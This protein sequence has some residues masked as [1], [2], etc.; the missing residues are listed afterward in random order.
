MPGANDRSGPRRD[1]ALG[2]GG[3]G[4][5][6]SQ[7]GF[8]AVSMLPGAERADRSVD[9]VAAGAGSALD[10]F[11]RTSRS[12]RSAR[13]IANGDRQRL[14]LKGA[15]LSD[16]V[17]PPTRSGNPRA[18]TVLSHILALHVG[19]VI[20]A[21]LYFAREVLIPFALAMLLSF[22]LAPAADWLHRLRIGRVPSVML[23]ALFALGIILSVGGVI[24]SQVAQLAADIPQYATAIEK[25]IE[26]VRAHTLDRFNAFI[27][28]L[29][30]PREGSESRQ[31]PPGPSGAGSPTPNTGAQPVS[32]PATRPSL[33][34]LTIRYLSP[35]LSP[36]ATI[37]IVLVV[38]IFVLL[39]REDLRDRLI[40]LFGTTDLHRT[41]DALD[42]AARRLSVYFLTQL[43]I[44]AG[45]GVVI[46]IGLY[47]IGVPNP[48][49]W[50]MLS[51]LL[52]FVPYIG[53][54]LSAALPIMLAAAVE[55][56]WST[57]IWTVALYVAVD[58]IVSQ[59]VEPMLYG[60]GTGLSPISV[61]VA[62]I[63]WSW[64]WGPIGLIL[65]MPLTLCLVVF[66]RHVERLK[67]LDIMLGDQPALT[68]VERFY[69][70]MLAADTDEVEENAESYLKD[71][72]LLSYY[73]DVVLSGLRLAAADAERGA[74]REDQLDQVKGTMRAL[75]SELADY[76][77]NQPAASQSEEGAAV[78]SQ[79][80]AA[81][82]NREPSPALLSQKPILCVAGR[83]PLDAS[84]S[85]ILA[86]LLE[87]AGL[88]VRLG[89]QEAVSRERL[90][91]L[92][93]SE[94]AMVCV[95]YL[96][97]SGTPS[98]LRYLVQRLRRRLP[99]A[100]IVV[101]FWSQDDNLVREP[102]ARALIGADYYAISLHDSLECC[103]GAARHASEKGNWEVA[104]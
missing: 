63:F 54:Y 5:Y 64:L 43:S 44:N 13:L 26:T 81:R 87:K 41:T 23:A 8:I 10:V 99:H 82:D 69:Q 48:V 100:P 22:L 58:I 1:S 94:I 14:P 86:Q 28:R 32:P 51:G 53:T 47:L 39:Q 55:P 70:R 102:T 97:I 103:L 33:L 77:A 30:H 80:A 29:G 68:P 73:E 27:E 66:G 67:F 19:V 88:G 83:G 9:Q 78:E 57:A 36:L 79:T 62:A 50:G 40:R 52:R 2:T 35:A 16:L 3:R 4:A 15:C 12:L 60:H 92:D 84:A 101:G 91:L 98:H 11:R 21:A 85:A 7:R 24:G 61:I 72:S 89:P 59:A 17:P 42:D 25:K 104:A 49:L 37:G 90:P 71:H 46:G 75:L 56:G 6:L 65:S 20:V 45:F 96:E 31:I 93:V 34:V 95:T 74:L 76:D 38:T 18:A